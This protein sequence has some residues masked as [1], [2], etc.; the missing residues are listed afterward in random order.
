MLDPVEHHPR[1]R[2]PGVRPRRDE[3]AGRDYLA[4]GAGLAGL[5]TE[6]AEAARHEP[7]PTTSSP[8]WSHAEVDGERLT[9]PGA[10]ARSSSC[11]ASP[12]TR[13]PA[14]RSPT[15]SGACTATPTS[16]RAWP[17]DFDGVTPTAVEEIVRWASPVNWMRR[18]V[19]ADTTVGGRH[20]S[21]AG[22]QAAAVLRLGQPRRG[23][24]SPTP[25][26]STCAAPPT[27]TSRLRRPR[28]ALLPRRPPRPPRGRGDVPAAARPRCRTSRSSA[29]PTGCARTSSTGSSTCRSGCLPSTT[30]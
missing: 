22:R 19:A 2:R 26:A 3:P 20:R 14:T 1:R 23:R 17:A 25:T 18:T 4:A 29:S 7:R 11:S 15:A 12:A 21:S 6:L 13:P 30:G 27:R 9:P 16:A 28:P 24:A 5:M 10:R 8:R